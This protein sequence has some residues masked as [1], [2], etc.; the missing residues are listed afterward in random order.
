MLLRACA[1][2]SWC[3]LGVLQRALQPDDAAA[4][5]FNSLTQ[6]PIKQRSHPHLCSQMGPLS[7]PIALSWPPSPAAGA[8][9]AHLLA[10]P[11]LRSALG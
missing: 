8:H 6:R 5:L 9:A 10:C 2:A 11:V 7:W 1:T 4:C 3:V